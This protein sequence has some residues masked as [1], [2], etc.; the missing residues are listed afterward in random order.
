M[1]TEPSR[2]EW[3]KA[4]R[5]SIGA[6]E[7]A[8]VLGLHP[9]HSP[10]SLYYEKTTEVPPSEEQT[11]YQEWGHLMEEPLAAKYARKTNRKVLPGQF[12]K[13]PTYSFITA[14]TDRY[15]EATTGQLS[16]G[17]GAQLALGDDKLLTGA[18]ELKTSDRFDAT[19]ELP[20]YWQI[21]NQQQMACDNLL[22][23]SFSILG[24]FRRHYTADLLRNEKFISFLIEKEEEFWKTYVIPGI[25]PPAD[26]HK[27]TTE[28]L[29]RMYP[30]DNGRVVQL[31]EH[32]AVNVRR[33]DGVKEAIKRLESLKAEMENRVKA[34]IGDAT[35]G[36]LPDGTGWSLKTTDRAGYV[37]DPTS[38]RTLRFTKKVGK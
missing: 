20:L 2:V 27:A 37:V 15:C 33:I 7:A 32:F 30:K 1:N 22:F 26:G 19:D 25:P 38:Y 17:L 29:K 23:G 6:S 4:R 11:D 10:L 35:W 14:T 18:L 3:L 36:Q 31:A 9:Y 8:A 12:R 28:A 16:G 5:N 21:Q 24:P 13:H 34:A